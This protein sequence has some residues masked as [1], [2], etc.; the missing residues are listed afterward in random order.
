MAR[1]TSRLLSALHRSS[2]S[3]PSVWTHDVAQRQVH[4]K[5]SHKPG[6]RARMQF[7]YAW[8]PPLMS[9]V[10]PQR[11]PLMVNNWLPSTLSVHD[12]PR[13]SNLEG[14]VRMGLAHL[15]GE[16]DRQTYLAERRTVAQ[17]KDNHD[18]AMAYAP[19]GQRQS[20]RRRC[21]GRS[22]EARG[23]ARRRGRWWH[24]RQVIDLL[25]KLIQIKGYLPHQL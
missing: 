10:A 5:P 9:F 11:A 16:I 15:T 18:K 2:V 21:W 24:G 7:E 6:L 1:Q 20:I 19:A 4:S 8:H 17:V 13:I 23:R 22:Q 25:T 12:V 14:S 3:Q